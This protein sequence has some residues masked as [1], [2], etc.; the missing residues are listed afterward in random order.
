MPVLKTIKTKKKVR[1]ADY[2]EWFPRLKGQ[3]REL[4]QRARESNLPVV[5]V[6]EG[7]SMAGKGDCIRHLT[8]TLDPRGFSV[9]AIYQ[10]TEEEARRHWLWR[11]WLRMPP[12]GRM[13]FFERSWYTRVLEERVEGLCSEKEWS[14]AYQEINQTEGMLANDG[15]LVIKFWLHISK[16]EQKKRLKQAEEDP[17]RRYHVT[18]RDWVHHGRYK[19]YRRA[20]QEMIERTS[21]HLAPWTI[22]E[23]GDHRFRRMKVFQTLSEKI[24]AEINRLAKKARPPRRAPVTTPAA[25]RSVPVLEEM[26]TLLD[27]VDLSQKLSAGEYDERKVGLQVRLRRMQY[28]A[29]KAKLPFI[30]LYEGWDAAG[31]G[32]N[33]RRL[34]ATLDPRF[35]DVIPVSKPT[36]EELARHYLWR[37]W[38]NLPRTGHLTIFD[39]S[40]YGRVMVERIE[41]FCTEEEWRRAYQEINEFEMQLTNERIPIVKFWLHISPEEQLRRFEAR[42]ADPHKRW[43]LT[44]EDWRNRDKWGEYREAVVD[45]VKAT[46][47]TY[48]PWTILEGECKR[49]ARVRALETVIAAYQEALGKAGSGKK[50]K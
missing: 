14:S 44:D 35:Y 17:F 4:Q 30:T 45:M 21:T 31:K 33:I 9:H 26:P 6:F 5:V 16:Q 3:L 13:A 49:F 43:K 2:K 29:T 42:A 38:R 11:F 15:A 36:P 28:E 18:S 40:W 48:A 50:K 34:T 22:V 27:Q 10:P 20:A 32:G 24:A 41:G 1:K 7:L 47:T 39:R 8:E 37:F 12:R 25:A 19:D 46:S 23:S